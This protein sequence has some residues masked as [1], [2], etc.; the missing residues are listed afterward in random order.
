MTDRLTILAALL[1]ETGAAHHRAFMEVD[2]DDPEWP[3]WYTDHM[4]D[5]LRAILGKPI[6]RSQI[7]YLLVGAEQAQQAAGNDTPWPLFFAR[8]MLDNAR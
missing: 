5:R 3:M 7:I 2:G 6:T 1:E 8:F 4:H